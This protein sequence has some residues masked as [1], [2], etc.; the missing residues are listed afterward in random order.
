M[1]KQNSEFGKIKPVEVLN[2]IYYFIGTAG[3]AW[4]AYIAAFKTLP[5][6]EAF[7]GII[8]TAAIPA[9]QSIFK[10]MLK[11]SDGKLFEKEKSIMINDDTDPDTGGATFPPRK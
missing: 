8:A 2:A 3:G 1:K 6:T 5:S 10:R 11:N 7:I 9:F 4:L